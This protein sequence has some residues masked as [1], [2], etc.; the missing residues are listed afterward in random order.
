MGATGKCRKVLAA[1]AA[2]IR[3]VMLPARNLKDLDEVPE[4]ARQQLEFVLL[5]DVAQA[6]EVALRPAGGRLS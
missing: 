6:M 1:L 2:G 3:C 5:H 4:E